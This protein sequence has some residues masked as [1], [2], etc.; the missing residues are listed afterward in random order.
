MLYLKSLIASFVFGV[1]LAG[2]F[3]PAAQ[4]VV[5]HDTLTGVLVGVGCGLVHV[6][7]LVERNGTITR[8]RAKAVV[9]QAV[10]VDMVV[11]MLIGVAQVVA[12]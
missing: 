6:V 7:A 2:L 9:V 4:G 5:F 1:V 11:G 10:R 8:R 3:N 12:G